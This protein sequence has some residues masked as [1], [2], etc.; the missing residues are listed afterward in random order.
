[1]TAVRLKHISRFRDRHGHLRH[2]LRL[3]GR[4]PVALPGAPGSAEFM[5]A[6]NAAVTAAA[7]DEPKKAPEPAA[8]TFDALAVAYYASTAFSNLRASTQAAYRRIVEEVRRKHGNKP[9]RLL[10]AEGVRVLMGEKSEHV[11]AANHR[12]R[13]LRALMG[14][15]VEMKMI[16]A[17]PTAGVR[18]LRY[19]TDGYPT[20]S[21]ADIQLYEAK[22]PSGTRERLALALLLYTGQRR[23]DVVR[24]GRQHLTE[25]VLPDGSR[26]PGIRVRQV[27]TGHE[28][29]IPLHA[30]LAAELAQVPKDQLTYLLTS[31]GKPFSPRGFYNLFR[32]WCDDAGVPPGRSPHGL[33]KGCGRRLAEAGATA[34]QIMSVL[35]LRTLALAEVYTRAA[36]QAR[37]AAEGMDRIANI[38]SNPAPPELPTLQKTGG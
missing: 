30:E 13:L 23:S 17:D 28:I 38:T 25:I 5:A 21:E 12:L 24:M 4:K 3:P 35:G 15:A 16:A 11:T 34:H 2:Y 29:A 14:R 8:G 26:R 6:Y 31:F 33:R 1:M 18:R 19:R 27:K 36:A 9:V 10:D 20:W 7:A 32:D 22:W 37:M